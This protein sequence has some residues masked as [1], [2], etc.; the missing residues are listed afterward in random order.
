MSSNITKKICDKFRMLI[1]DTLTLFPNSDVPKWSLTKEWV[2]FANIFFSSSRPR[3]YYIRSSYQFFKN[4]RKSI[5]TGIQQDKNKA[6]P[7]NS[8]VMATEF[9]T[10]LTS[11]DVISADVITEVNQVDDVMMSSGEKRDTYDGV[12][13]DFSQIVSSRGSNVPN[14]DSNIGTR[15]HD[16]LSS[17][18]KYQ[19]C[20]G[21][22]SFR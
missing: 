3:E 17:D 15:C 12:S 10:D 8:T 21:D 11:R 2:E 18:V 14:A 16:V 1:S 22:H 5:F 4:N 13:D 20:Q 19:S 9:D 7:E 6:K